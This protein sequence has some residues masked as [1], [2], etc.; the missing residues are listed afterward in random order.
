MQLYVKRM[1][2]A[3]VMQDH[4]Q[5]LC[6]LKVSDMWTEWLCL[7]AGCFVAEELSFPGLLHVSYFLSL[8][9]T[10]S[11]LTHNTGTGAKAACQWYGRTGDYL[12]ALPL[13]CMAVFIPALIPSE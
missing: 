1:Q 13:W 10:F 12:T 5:F 7:A 11:P 9:L 3:E 8:S 4:F 2:K 6:V